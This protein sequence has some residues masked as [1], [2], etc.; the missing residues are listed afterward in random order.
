MSTSCRTIAW[1]GWHLFARSPNSHVA[2]DN[3]QNQPPSWVV[4]I[5]TFQSQLGLRV[6]GQRMVFLN[7]GLP[8]SPNPIE[9]LAA[10][11]PDSEL[12]Q[13]RKEASIP[14]ASHETKKRWILVWSQ[15][16]PLPQRDLPPAARRK[17]QG[18][19]A[20]VWGGFDGSR[21]GGV[22]RRNGDTGNSDQYYANS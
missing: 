2:P 16:K 18:K 15:A 10:S 13:E 17:F 8:S 7:S 4:S 6:D 21:L 5:N 22:G 1:V 14:G 19:V 11:Y 9:A 3:P 20:R 12:A